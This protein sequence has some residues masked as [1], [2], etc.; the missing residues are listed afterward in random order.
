MKQNHKCMRGSL[1]RKRNT[2][3]R[4]GGGLSASGVRVVKSGGGAG[5]AV[6][7][8][9]EARWGGAGQLGRRGEVG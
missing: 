6:G 3:E 5:H 7:R 4:N 8:G 1:G 9:G 2:V